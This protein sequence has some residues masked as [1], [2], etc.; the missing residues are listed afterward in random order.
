[1]DPSVSYVQWT[2]GWTREE[3]GSV[4]HEVV[5]ELL[6]SVQVPSPVTLGQRR[7]CRVVLHERGP[8]SLRRPLRPRR[9][10]SDPSVRPTLGTPS[11]TGR[12]QGRAGRWG[13]SRWTVEADVGPEGKGDEPSR[14]DRDAVDVVH[15]DS[16]VRRLSLGS[17]NRLKP[18]PSRGGPTLGIDPDGPLLPFEVRVSFVRS[19]TSTGP[20]GP[21]VTFGR[22]RPWTPRFSFPPT[23]RSCRG[24]RRLVFCGTQPSTSLRQPVVRKWTRE[25]SEFP[26]T[27][28]NYDTNTVRVHGMFRAVTCIPYVLTSKYGRRVGLRTRGFPSLFWMAES[29]KPEVPSPL[30]PVHGPLVRGDFP[31]VETVGRS[32]NRTYSLG[33]KGQ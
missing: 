28:Q 4:S 13:P 1:M 17:D 9:S 6:E 21:C 19:R 2:R 24:V 20:P 25:D 33:T 18:F 16:A 12:G 22:A 26:N 27:V 3:T 32:P 31:P 23:V 7:V 5:P 15:L 14:P 8:S 10:A 30:F 29:K 11:V